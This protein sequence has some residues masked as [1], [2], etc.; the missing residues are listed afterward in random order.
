MRALNDET[1][2]SNLKFLTPI[3]IE[4][5]S[6][7]YNA[8]KDLSE[9]LKSAKRAN[10]R[11]IAVSGPY[12]AGKSS[13]LLTLQQNFQQY[14]Y[15]PISLAT[16]DPEMDGDDAEKS[17]T[18]D[19]ESRTE[20]SM[21]MLNRKIEYSILQQLLYREKANTV[22]HSRFRRIN[23]PELKNYLCYFA[24]FI[25][26][27]ISFICLFE[28]SV[29]YVHS[30][31]TFFDF[32]DKNRGCD[33][34]AIVILIGTTCVLVWESINLLANVRL[35]KLTLR[36][37]G[38]ELS[39]HASI[40][41]KYL[42]EILYFFQVT[43]Y[44]V[45]IFEDLDRFNTEKIFL[46]LRELNQ[47][48][49]ESKIVDR[50][51]TFVYAVK[52]DIFKDEYRT[53]FFDYIVTVIPV[54]NASNSMSKLKQ[55]LKER[56]L[57]QDSE[58]SDDELS[59]IGFFIEDMR[60]LTNIVNEFEQY[61]KSLV[62]N[63]TSGLK[64]SK[65]LAMIT[66]KNLF[67]RDF[68][69]LRRRDG[70]LYQFI[71]SKPQLQEYLTN[72][73][74]E[75][76]S[77]FEGLIDKKDRE[78]FSKLGEYIEYLGSK[79]GHSDFVALVIEHE[80]HSRD[81][82]EWGQLEDYETSTDIIQ[83]ISKGQRLYIVDRYNRPNRDLMPD[84]KRNINRLNIIVQ[85]ISKLNKQIKQQKTLRLSIEKLTLS[86][87]IA[88]IE[89][90]EKR[91]ITEIFSLSP[92]PLMESFIR[93]GLIAEDYYDYV[94]YFYEGDISHSDWQYLLDLKL[95]RDVSFDHHI[96]K[97]VNLVSKLEMYMFDC[98]GIY[99]L[100]LFNYLAS[101]ESEEYKFTLLIDRIRSD[102]NSWEAMRNYVQQGE[103]VGKIFS[104]V[105][106]GR[107]S[108]TWDKVV[109]LDEEGE[110]RTLIQ[111]HLSYVDHL[112]D[113][114]IQWMNDHYSFVADHFKNFD[115]KRQR[116][117]LDECCFNFMNSDNRHFL[118]IVVKS[119][120]F[121]LN[122]S[123]LSLIVRELINNEKEFNLTQLRKLGKLFSDWLFENI[124]DVI[125]AIQVKSSKTD[126][127]ETIELLLNDPVLP[128]DL[129]KSYLT[130]QK[131]KISNI[132]VISGDK[133]K[134]L[135]VEENLIEPNW[136]NIETYYSI[137]NKLTKELQ[138]FI[139]INCD[140]LSQ[141]V[142]LTNESLF[143][144]L[145]NTN[146]LDIHCYDKLLRV[147]DYVFEEE[148]N[149][150]LEKER[151]DSLIYAGKVPFTQKNTAVLVDTAALP[152][153]LIHHRKETLK[154]SFKIT[155]KDPDV[156]STIL[157]NQELS[158]YEK[159]IFSKLMVWS[160]IISN[161]EL[162][163]QVAKVY[164]AV[165]DYEFEPRHIKLIPNLQNQTKKSFV[166]KL[167]RQEDRVNGDICKDVLLSMEGVYAEF[168]NNGKATWAPNDFHCEL[169]SLLR[170]RLIIEKYYKSSGKVFLKTS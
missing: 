165:D 66:Y 16:L 138:K 112:I 59:E 143:N 135:A 105:I 114:Q 61:H 14:S 81:R 34:L 164:C 98:S 117:I 93:R 50:H 139:E 102:S 85:D 71:A 92:K 15:L 162:S 25:S 146:V 65:L 35:S 80:D 153:Y 129:K 46:K 120:S 33:F 64:L 42:D 70:L 62:G 31:A 11:N 130:G 22:R 136:G 170:K 132:A 104:A 86:K 166:L 125:T 94:S 137:K 77:T 163:E 21:E 145:F 157:N 111:A 119:R 99:N 84:V 141:D 20:E 76:I 100:E 78:I 57:L 39:E 67:P 37:G 155:I 91:N 63:H 23:K 142:G 8:V 6:P 73:I 134:Q 89:H 74:D 49:N 122:Y 36:E 147:S 83:K 118:E 53:K 115:Q 161:V 150:N 5:T 96:D 13:V 18:S 44:D 109:R 1:L 167:L 113:E 48:I 69:G 19:S 160:T 87:L 24:L 149:S 90:Q 124:E 45:V 152:T 10:L 103:Y 29:F 133:N 47:L 126:S 169:V 3:A 128:I 127:S 41:N 55:V 51:V 106:E 101:H 52:D 30:I 97:M 72:S 116:E 38:F 43:S 123:N 159:Y 12:G 168:L 144:S 75:K 121:E 156:M 28:P 7:S 148:I 17:D 56:G 140:Q 40:F 158:Q 58:I 9:A 131:E 68:E 82:Y 110:D 95:N 4:K 2:A 154:P 32:G 27:F 60:L 26:A 54:I 107:E 151:L 108:E 88:K 79:T